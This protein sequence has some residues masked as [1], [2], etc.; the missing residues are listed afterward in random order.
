MP[1]PDPV[2][3]ASTG[4]TNDDVAAL[5]VAGAPEGTCVVAD[6]QTAGRGRLD[7]VWVS[8]PG[9]GLWT[10]VLVRVGDQPK[11]RWGLLSLA[12]GVACVDA[13]ASAGGIRVELKWP[14]DV[15]VVA[16]ACGASVGY[17]KLGGI[18]SQTVGDDG[19]VIGVG[20]NVSLR[21]EELPVPEATSVFLEGGRP[22]RAGLLVAL[23]TALSARLDQWRRDDPAL[24]ADYRQACRTIG[25]RVEVSMPDGS[26]L[27]GIVSDVDD[28][29]HLCVRDGERT[30]TVTA[31]DV[32]HAS[33]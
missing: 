7:R 24:L 11:A 18:L 17:R 6:E 33:L 3:V 30:V 31:G 21:S 22:D 25:R 10:S 12:A 26:M 27:A 23:M 15:V 29:G 9:A 19:V 20:L 5:A 32:V 2:V 1:W 13:L 4:S 16:A 8:P 14:N 28:A